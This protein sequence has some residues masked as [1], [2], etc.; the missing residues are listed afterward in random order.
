MTAQE[1]I[2]NELHHCAD[3]ALTEADQK[4]LE[5]QG[6]EAFVY[7]KLTSK[8]FRKWAIDENSEKQAKRAIEL[9]ISQNKPLQ[10]RYPFGGY[11]LWRLPGSPET[12]WAEFFAIAYCC[13]YLAPIAA[14]YKPG[15]E[16]LFGSDDVIIERMDNIPTADTDAYFGSFKQLLGEFRKHLPANFALDI[17][18]IGDLYEDKDE[19]EQELAA[20]VKRLKH[21]YETTVPEE[22]KQKMYVTSE[23]NIRMDGVKDLTKLSD[24]EK[25]AVIEMGPIY[26][27]AQG[28]LSKRRE[29]HRGED[30]IVIFTIV[31]PNAIAIGTTKTSITKFWTGV[32]AVRPNDKDGFHAVILSPSQLEKADFSWQDI[33]VDGLTGKNFSKIRM[34]SVV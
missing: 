29:F 12:D 16:L 20:S 26:H 23:L 15:I 2:E 28:A 13:R 17:I 27:D 4:L 24:E 34:L 8:K 25:Q 14:A 22:R 10:F 19:L 11:K 30:K 5:T 7:A 33:H 18:R 32:G 31:V 3:Y 9:N 21:E 1:Y 6:I